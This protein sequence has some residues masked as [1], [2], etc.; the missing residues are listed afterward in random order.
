MRALR[1]K[2]AP[3]ALYQAFWDIFLDITWVEDQRGPALVLT[4]A[5]PLQAGWQLRHEHLMQGLPFEAIL[6][7]WGLRAAA[8]AMQGVPLLSPSPHQSY[9]YSLILQSY[10]SALTLGSC[11]KEIEGPA[12][13]AAL[14]SGV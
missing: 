5:M 7:D 9:E 2:I 13:R 14:L 1:H 10:Q 8:H 12:K 11:S 3:L 4:A 6:M